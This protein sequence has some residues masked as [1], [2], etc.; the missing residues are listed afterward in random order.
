MEWK[1]SFFNI[2]YGFKTSNNEHVWSK[3]RQ[4]TSAKDKKRESLKEDHIKSEFN[5]KFFG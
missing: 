5:Q 1:G 3:E 2:Q 4:I